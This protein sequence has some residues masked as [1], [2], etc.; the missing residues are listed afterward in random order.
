VKQKNREEWAC[1]AL[2]TKVPIWTIDKKL[3]EVTLKLGLEYK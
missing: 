1:V 3:K 2:L